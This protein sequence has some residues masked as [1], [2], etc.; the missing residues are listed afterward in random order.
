MLRLP[1]YL[2]FKIFTYLDLD[3]QLSMYD[4]YTLINDQ[5][6]IY[7]GLDTN[8]SHPNL[9]SNI[10]HALSSKIQSYSP[11][12]YSN[13]T[14]QCLVLW[15]DESSHYFLKLD[16]FDHQFISISISQ[17]QMSDKKMLLI[18]QGYQHRTRNGIAVLQNKDLLTPFTEVIG[19][20]YTYTHYSILFEYW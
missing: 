2:K 12:C 7:F 20:G 14:K 4:D 19:V 18:G 15:Y 13:S 9:F 3:I 16:D 10:K 11:P 17:D 1:D 6:M 8:R 5:S